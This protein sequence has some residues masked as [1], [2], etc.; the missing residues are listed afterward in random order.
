MQGRYDSYKQ[1]EHQVQDGVRVYLNK[2]TDDYP[3]HWHN[4]FELILPMV[5]SY[6]VAVGDESHVLMPG[7]L[8]IIPSR[9]VHEIFAPESGE[10]LIFIIDYSEICHIAGMSVILL[11]F[12]PCVILSQKKDGASYERV[13][14]HLLSAASEYDREDYFGRAATRELVRLAFIEVGRRLME[15]GTANLRDTQPRKLHQTTAIYMDV[16]NYIVEHCN[17]KLTLEEMAKYSGYSKYHFSRMFKKFSGMS[18]YDFYVNQRMLLCERLLTDAS[19]T[20]TEAAL[21][22]GFGSIATFNRVFKQYKGLTPTAFR[23]NMWK[24]HRNMQENPDG[25]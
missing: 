13:K 24:S 23:R 4:S 25:E 10:R 11:S 15:S 6:T 14:K 8:M 1:M 18:F 21:R 16:C 2:Q 17:Q 9:A 22:S 19:I 20:I 12:Y 7:D 3:K 5:N